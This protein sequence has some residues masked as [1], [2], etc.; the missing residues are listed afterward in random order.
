MQWLSKNA[1]HLDEHIVGLAPTPLYYNHFQ[2][3]EPLNLGL[4][5]FLRQEMRGEDI[6]ASRGV[7][8]GERGYL[9]TMRNFPTDEPFAWEEQVAH[10]P[11][12]HF[13]KRDDPWVKILR[14]MVTASAEYVR[15]RLA[16]TDAVIEIF[17]SWIQV[18]EN[19]IFHTFHNH[20]GQNFHP[21]WEHDAN[22]R[23]LWSGAYYVDDGDPDPRNDYSGVLTI[24]AHGSLVHVR[25]KPGLMLM[26]PSDLFHF[27]NPFFGE[28]ERIMVSWNLGFIRR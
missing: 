27:V 11:Q 20:K 10:V 24:N 5:R 21:V 18:Y 4:T 13:L 28:R 15:R 16:D 3:T 22:G 12:N 25:P 1:V 2:S 14:D 26:W 7:K 23:T 17:N 6:H 9:S 19:G 8:E